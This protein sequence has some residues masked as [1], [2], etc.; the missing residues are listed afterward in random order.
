MVFYANGV[1][2][3]LRGPNSLIELRENLGSAV[4]ELREAQ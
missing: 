2:R 1:S 3:K 4:M